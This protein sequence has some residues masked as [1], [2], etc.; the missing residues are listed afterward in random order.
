ML[1]GSGSRGLVY[2]G[3]V[4]ALQKGKGCYYY[5]V[6]VSASSVGSLLYQQNCT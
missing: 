5:C 3:I 2:C 4:A 6:V 1:L